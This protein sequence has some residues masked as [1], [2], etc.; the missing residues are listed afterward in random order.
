MRIYFLIISL[1]ERNILSIAEL[2]NI[3]KPKRIDNGVF[4]K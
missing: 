1:I 4:Y 3:S 2:L